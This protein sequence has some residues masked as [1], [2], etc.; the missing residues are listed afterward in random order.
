MST[1][2]NPKKGSIKPMQRIRASHTTLAY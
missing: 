2:P 1:F